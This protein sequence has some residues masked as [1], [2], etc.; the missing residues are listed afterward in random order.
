MFGARRLE[1]FSTYAFAELDELKAQVAKKMRVIDMGVGDPDFPPP[2]EIQGALVVALG[3]IENHRYPSYQGNPQL[4]ESIARF[5]LNRY[6]V[7]L[8]PEENV[9]VLI[10][11]KE[12]IFHLPLAVLNPGDVGVY[13]EPGYP[14]YRAGIVFAGGVPRSIPLRPENNFLL[15]PDD[16]PE[17]AKLVWINY[18]NNPTSAVAGRE[19]LER[20]VDLAHRRGFLIANDAAYNEIYFDNPPPSILEIPGA[21]DVAVEFH[22]LSKTFSMTGWRVG[23]MVG[24]REVIKAMLTLKKYVDSGVFGAVQEAA[25]TALDNYFTLV[26]DIRKIYARRV[27]LWL[28]VLESAGIS[29]HNFGATFYVWARVPDGFENSAAFCK[30]LLERAGIVAMPGSAM[31][32]AGEGFVRFSMTL[33]DEEIKFAAEKIK[34]L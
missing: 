7:K 30:H 20:I 5:F 29:A 15:D 8:D 19:F 31:G 13:T 24:N 25:K 34:Q 26:D 6:K 2:K 32:D 21:M 17:D 9:I 27:R 22:S 14:V 16:I 1:Q 11:S 33:P 23:F 4:R 18:P 28:E 12:G 3:E 10:G